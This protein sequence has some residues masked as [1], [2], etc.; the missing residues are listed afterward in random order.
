MKGDLK[1][2]EPKLNDTLTP[3]RTSKAHFVRASW[4]ALAFTLFVIL[5]GAFVRATGSGAGCGSHWPLC[6]GEVLPQD[7]TLHTV[8]EFTHRATSG[9]SLL[10]VVGL[11][12]WAR[13][14]Y[15]ARTHFV[16]RMAK[17]SLIGMILE[18]LLGAGLVL[19]ELVAE[20]KSVTRAVSISLH[21]VN[22]SFLTAAMTLLASGASRELQGRPLRALWST[23][24][25]RK[26]A[27]AV[28][29]TFLLLG[30]AGAITALGDT[31]FKAE[32]LAQGIQMDLAP[33]AHFLLKLRV[34]HPVLAVL[35]GV[36]SMAW[37]LGLRYHST[38]STKLFASP[39]Q[40][41]ALLILANLL[42]GAT[43]LLLLAP[44][45]L[46]LAHLLMANVIWIHLVL[47]FSGEEP[48]S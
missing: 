35:W 22:T 30:A 3:T 14:L 26:R 21:L 44:T 1:L 23:P 24:L 36:G 19:L 27:Q 28:L 12:V 41:A 6:N 37:L 20:D 15:P 10:L 8:I 48:Q 40:R 39:T 7:P 32:S 25:L 34:I 29:L 31:L 9:I 47:T 13:K 18:A 33:G 38:S 43:N 16:R 2:A 17:L 11:F 42:L 46:Q 4:A 45:Q 5:W